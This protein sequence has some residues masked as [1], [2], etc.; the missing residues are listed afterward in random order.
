MERKGAPLATRL[1]SRRGVLGGAVAAAAAT[2]FLP[3]LAGT[4]YGH[5]SRIFS[6]GVGSGDPGPHSVVL[7]TRL[8]P[9]PLE[10]GGMPNVPVPVYWEVATDRRMRRV[11][12]RGWTLASPRDGHSVHVTARG[13]EPDRWYWYRFVTCGE[14]SPIGRT[15]TFPS[16]RECPNRM[17]FALASCQDYQNGLYSAYQN[18]AEEDLDFVVHV[19]DYIYE[20]GPQEGG[21]RQHIGPEIQTLDDYRN[22]Y[23]LYKMDPSLQAAHAAFPFICTWDD[24]EVDNNYAGLTPE[25]DQ[26]PE[27]FLARRTA[28]YKAYYENLPLRAFTRPNGSFMRLFRRLEFGKLATFHVLDTRQFRTDQP[29]GDGLKPACPEVFDEDATMTGAEQEAWLLRGL[30]RS[31]AIWNVLAQQIMFMKWDIGPATG[32]PIPFFNVDAW[33]GYVAARQRLTDF[34]VNA[35]P[36]NPVF[37]TGDIHS[38]WAAEILDSYSDPNPGTIATEF[39]TTSITSDFP[40]VFLPAVQATLPVNPHIKYFNGASRGY[41]RFNVTSKIWRA[42]FRGVD[43][44]LTPT[45]P[46]STLKSFVVQAGFAGLTVA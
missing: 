38:A 5:G 43:S 45:S 39:V 40:V 15:R 31:D 25:D 3:S 8:A 2:P 13:L 42:D 37:L 24:H 6:L 33:D 21:P 28:G 12:R 41:T 35:M 27:A 1:P 19:G 17:R 4:A 18:M 32:L 9:K 10:G 20:Y 23:A 29:C 22:R 7:W 14:D 16:M 36:N 34:I 46:V 26:T 30:S 44:I 11:V